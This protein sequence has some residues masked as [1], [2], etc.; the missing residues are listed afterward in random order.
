[1]ADKNRTQTND[2]VLR[3]MQSFISRY[4]HARYARASNKEMKNP[5]LGKIGMS[6][7]AAEMK[8]VVSL[9][10]QRNSNSYENKGI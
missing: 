6:E 5:N 10:F 7:F 9:Y 3:N 4:T 8:V 2:F 1:M